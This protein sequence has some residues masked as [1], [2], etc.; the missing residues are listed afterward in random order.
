MG[1]RGPKR[2]KLPGAGYA[3]IAPQKPRRRAPLDPGNFERRRIDIGTVG[4]K[5]Y[6]LIRITLGLWRRPI[7]RYGGQ[8]HQRL[9]GR[10]KVE[11]GHLHKKLDTPIVSIAN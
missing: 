2:S 9:A 6:K 3:L 7:F 1:R 8:A 4:T 5:S 11:N 10:I